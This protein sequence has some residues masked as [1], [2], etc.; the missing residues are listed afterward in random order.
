MGTDLHPK[1]NINSDNLFYYCVGR[2]RTLGICS[3]N[4]KDMKVSL[5][6]YLKTIIKSNDKHLRE[7]IALNEKSNEK[8][9]LIFKETNSIHLASL[10]N[11]YTR[12]DIMLNDIAKK[13]VSTD[14]HAGFREIVDRRFNE[15]E[16]QHR[17][18]KGAGK[19]ME[20]KETG[21][22]KLYYFIAGAILA[23][24]TTLINHYLKI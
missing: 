23:I 8:A 16:G 13:T 7:I 5:K 12:T 10:N 11:L 18:E 14:E 22:E 1:W 9:L 20:K 19:I 17:E 24:L 3:G 21:N 4:G 6:K 2:L 15:L